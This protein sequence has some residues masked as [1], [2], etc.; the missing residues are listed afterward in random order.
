MPYVDKIAREALGYVTVD[1]AP[2]DAGE[3]NYVITKVCDE[4]LKRKGRRYNNINTVIGVLACAQAEFY[5][6]VAAPY[7]NEKIA[8]NG[9][10]YSAANLPEVGEFVTLPN[11]LNISDAKVRS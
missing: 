7:E 10:V 5:R 6:R 1:E 3:L 11:A 8:V 4:F 2:E 9:D